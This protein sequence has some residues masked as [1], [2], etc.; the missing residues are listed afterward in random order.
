MGMDERYVLVFEFR[1]NFGGMSYIALASLF[2]PVHV[3]LKIN[4]MKFT[5]VRDIKTNKVSF[6]SYKAWHFANS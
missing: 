5:K 2:L 6:T 4:L 3:Q 1:M